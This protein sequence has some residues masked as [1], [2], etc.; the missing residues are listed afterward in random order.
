[1]GTGGGGLNILP[2]KSWN[3]YNRDN[4]ERVRRDEERARQDEEDRIRR[5]RAATSELRRQTLLSK[6]GKNGGGR[7]EENRHVNLFA[8]QENAAE[9]AAP[10]PKPEADERFRLG[11]ERAS[12]WYTRSGGEDAPTSSGKRLSLPARV[13]REREEAE[14]ARGVKSKPAEKP[15]R[16]PRTEE[17]W[18]SYGLKF[19]FDKSSDA[20]AVVARGEGGG[21][22]EADEETGE[23]SR[24]RRRKKR[25]HQGGDRP[26][27]RRHRSG[28]GRAP[29]AASEPKKH[30]RRSTEERPS[31]L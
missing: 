8:D 22:N 23:S 11:G 3:V 25:R 21:G 16:K 29:S 31:A 20:K 7:Q 10:E 2:H 5:E 27:H 15:L 6:R 18:Q 19:L 12:P 26:R 9:R 24:R 4:R 17:E 28:E 30:K 14:E 1:M 13:R